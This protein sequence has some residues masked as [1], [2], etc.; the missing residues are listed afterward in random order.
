MTS[1]SRCSVTASSRPS[2]ARPAAANTTASTWPSA[3]LR[4]RV[5]TL[6]R[7]SQ[8]S[9]SGLA[10]STW[11]LRRRLLVP[12][13]APAG[14]SANRIPDLDTSASRGSSLGG[15]PA[16][17]RPDGIAVGRSFMLCTANCTWPLSKACSI[18]VVNNPL[19]PMAGRAL[20]MTRSPW[21]L[22][23]LIVSRRRG[24]ARVN[25]STT[26]CV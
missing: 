2:L 9:R 25:K 20:S 14:S 4:S 3:S 19:P 11:A 12:T 7:M 23:R 24:W 13:L 5:S 26:A 22:I 1:T 21:V 10:P 8:T 18:S 15:T 6:P 17:Q 16:M